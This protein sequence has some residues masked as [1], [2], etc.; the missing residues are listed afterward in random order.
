MN[1]GFTSNSDKENYVKKTKISEKN[2]ILN[3]LEGKDPKDLKAELDFS[4]KSIKEVKPNNIKINKQI[5]WEIEI[6]KN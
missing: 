6:N 3:G 5:H 4:E 1:D 2:K